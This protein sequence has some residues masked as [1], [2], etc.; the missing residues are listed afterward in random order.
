MPRVSCIGVNLALNQVG[1]IGPGVGQSQFERDG[2][3]ALEGYFPAQRID[4]AASAVRRLLRERPAEIVV[5][6]LQ[7]G[8]RS[9]WAQAS[10]PQTRSYSFNDVHLLCEEV[11][12]LA[13]ESQ[14]TSTLG[15]LLGEPPVLC[16]SSSYERGSSQPKHIDSLH[17]TPRTPHS[18]VT[19]WIALE[20]VHADSGPPICY[21]G[22]HRIPL[23]S[24]NDGTHHASRDEIL[25]W[26]D[27]I[28]VQIRLRGLRKKTFLAR[29]GDVLILHADLVHGG[30]PIADPKRSQGSLVSHYFGKADCADRGMDLVPVNRGYWMRRLRQPVRAEP[31]AFGPTCPFPEASYLARHPDVREAVD[32]RLCPSGEF[33]YRAHGF[34]EGRGV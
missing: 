8:Q 30:S 32:A 19:A 25:D 27:Y 9:F 31:Q 14:L 15:D 11:R 18:L 24:F 5:D 20:D 7:T 3:L 28:D 26:F 29:K 10:H 4:R 13:L 12:E 1:D 34:R 23:Y 2:Y 33:H 16:S 21:P 22:S 17:L 6:C